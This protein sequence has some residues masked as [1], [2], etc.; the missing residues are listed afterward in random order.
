MGSDITVLQSAADCNSFSFNTV[1][2]GICQS[3]SQGKQE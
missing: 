1:I 2:L 3:E